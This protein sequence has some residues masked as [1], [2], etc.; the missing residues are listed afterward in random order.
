MKSIKTQMVVY[1]GAILLFV[2]AGLGII[3]YV[4]ASNAIKSQ[5]NDTLPQVARQGANVVIER[6]NGL[7]GTLEVMA[8][9]ERIKD[10]NNSWED[11]KLL[12]QEEAKRNE[13]LFMMIAGLD[14]SAKTTIGKDINIKDREYFQKAIAGNKGISDPLVSKVDG[15]TSMVFAVPIKENG[16]IVGVL[17]AV[18]DGSNLSKIT[19]NITFGETG[20]AFMINK[21]GTTIAHSNLDLV[22]NMDNDFE[23]IKTDQKLASLVKLEKEMVEGK[24][25]TGKY[26][27]NGNAKFLGYAP[28]EG[29][30]WSLAVAAPESEV[31]A[32]VQNMRRSILIVSVIILLLGIGVMY[33]VAGLIATPIRAATEH[34]RVIS[35]GDLTRETSKKYME[36][37]DELGVLA[38]AI[39]T[40]QQS[41]K[42]VVKGVINESRNVENSVLAAGQAM[43]E[44]TNQ[45]QD[46]S[47]TTEELSAGMEETAASSEEMS[48]AATEIERAIG[49]IALKAQQGAVSAGEISTRA[50][51]LK[52][53]TVSSQKNAQN[54]YLNAQD[55]LIKA[56]EESKAVDQINV[57]SNA[58]LQITSQTNL[59]ALN[60]AIE[61]ARAGEA[62]RGFAVVAEEIRKLAE[63]SKDT[64]NEIQKV[65][66]LVVVSVENLSE[67]SENV[68]E[69]I[70]KQV[71]KDYDNMVEISEQYNKDAEFVDNLVSD[72]SATAQEL[73]ASVQEIT[74]VIEEIAVAAN[75]GAE[76]TT[77]IAQKSIMV[78]EKSDEVTEQAVVS[79][80]SSSNLIKMVSK[81]TV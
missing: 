2:C 7:I 14:G 3:S 79:K 62:G 43:A 71:L 40:M 10:T 26:E 17:A 74:K 12:L 69:F 67:S 53:N 78:V 15:S 29:T 64:V 32:G 81:F 51:E 36:R 80:D 47:A 21:A 1:I 75:E 33:F 72:F 23:S 13:H 38:T 11:K 22:K 55:R 73:T 68:L 48:A 45:I 66:K 30:G 44:L 76:G 65:T 16:V 35:T 77:N 39:D 24:A 18:R 56:I 54:I 37:N 6:I 60:A 63:N 31:M 46:V 8:N 49:S 57:L 19:N 27:Y 20:K 70:D 5:V 41:V 59:L 28:V 58:I 4:T 34:L 25:G 52:Q 42:D 9:S 50:S 61:A